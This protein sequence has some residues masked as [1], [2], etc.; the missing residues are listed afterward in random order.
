MGEY[1]QVFTTAETQEDA[2]RI[3]RAVVER[4]LAGCVQVVGPIT[5]T[6]WWEGEVQTSGEWLCVIKSQREAYERLEQAILDVHPYEV[7]EVLAIPVVAGSQS[8]L[9]WLDAE[10]GGA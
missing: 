1:I 2:Q 5:S 6:Y 8:Y 3:A 10:M 4:R 9:A 7:P